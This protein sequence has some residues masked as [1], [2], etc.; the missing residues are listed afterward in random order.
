MVMDGAGLGYF[1]MACFAIGFLFII[2]SMGER[3]G[4][5]IGYFL[6]AVRGL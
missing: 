5:S 4:A 3:G 2:S 1:I 6:H